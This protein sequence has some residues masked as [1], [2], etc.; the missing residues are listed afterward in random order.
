MANKDFKIRSK[1]KFAF[2]FIEDNEPE[3]TDRGGVSLDEILNNKQQLECFYAIEENI[4]NILDLK[5]GE[6]LLMKFNRDNPDSEG[7]IKRIS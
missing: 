6:R 7:F 1:R 4:D 5:P 2:A 3:S